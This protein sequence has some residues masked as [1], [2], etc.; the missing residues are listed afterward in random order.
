[1]TH[2][3]LFIVFTLSIILSTNVCFS[4]QEAPKNYSWISQLINVIP[5]SVI[6]IM[7]KLTPKD[8]LFLA[9]GTTAGLIGLFIYHRNAT[10]KARKD[11]APHATGTIGEIKMSLQERLK[12][13]EELKKQREELNKQNKQEE[14][15][16]IKNQMIAT[17]REKNTAYKKNKQENTPIENQ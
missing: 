8:A 5:D 9:G 13:M 4:A 15:E 10:Y 7:H 1:M 17:F 3:N 2:N 12:L 11:M 6:N 16:E 14:A